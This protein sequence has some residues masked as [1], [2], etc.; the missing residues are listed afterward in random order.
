MELIKFYQTFL[1]F[2]RGLLSIIAP[3]GACKYSPTCSE[4]TKQQVERL[5]VL[6][7]IILGGRRILS[8]R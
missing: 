3:G 4:Y 2:D 5:G 8:C 7:G 1:S 6:R